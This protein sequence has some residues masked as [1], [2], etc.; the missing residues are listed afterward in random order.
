MATP[1]QAVS[2]FLFCVCDVC[3]RPVPPS[4]NKA[5]TS[6]RLSHPQLH[7]LYII[8]HAHQTRNSKH[9]NFP[10]VLDDAG[11]AGLSEYLYLDAMKN[12]I[13]LRMERCIISC[14]AFLKGCSF[15]FVQL[16]QS[17]S[18]PHYAE[19]QYRCNKPLIKQIKK[20]AKILLF[21][22]RS[23]AKYPSGRLINDVVVLKP[24]SFLRP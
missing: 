23:V 1:I 11:M 14:V 9:R 22:E 2:F 3:I 10:K 8:S 16:Q 5:S 19:N 20:C 24:L 15:N 4:S 6:T 12:E 7:Q 18:R 17:D 13:L 21:E